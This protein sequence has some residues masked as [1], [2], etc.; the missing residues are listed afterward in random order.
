VAYDKD[1]KHVIL[2]SENLDGLEYENQRQEVGW[3][4][5]RTPMAKDEWSSPRSAHTNQRH[6]GPRAFRTAEAGGEM[7]AEADLAVWTRAT[8]H[9]YASRR[10]H[11]H[12][13]ALWAFLDAYVRDSTLGPERCPGSIHWPVC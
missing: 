13:E 2:E 8:C 6:V 11:R 9:R 10:E 4:A 3:R 5:G 12:Y 1:P 7:A